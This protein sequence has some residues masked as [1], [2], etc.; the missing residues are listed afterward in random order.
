MSTGPQITV[1][2]M[3]G[4]CTATIC[5]IVVCCL[6]AASATPPTIT[7]EFNAVSYP[8]TLAAFGSNTTA[9]H[10]FNG[11]Q[12]GW[13]GTVNLDIT[14]LLSNTRHS[15]EVTY[16]G[17][18]QPEPRSFSTK[19]VAG[20]DFYLWNRSCDHNS[21]LGETPGSADWPMLR[22]QIPSGLNCAG[23]VWA[24]DLGYV[25]DL[26]VADQA[27]SGHYWTLYPNAYTGPKDSVKSY[28]YALAWLSLFGLFGDTSIATGAWGRDTDRVWG[29]MNFNIFPQWDD[30]EF[31][32]NEG[33]DTVTSASLQYPVNK[34]LWDLL[35]KPLYS[36]QPSIKSA[37]LNANHW[38]TTLG[39]LRLVLLDGITN[40]NGLAPTNPTTAVLYGS[41]GLVN[42]ISDALT[43]LNTSDAFKTLFT[44]G[45]L[46]NLIASDGV[47]NAY[48]AQHPLKNRVPAEYKRLFTQVG[49]APKSIMDNPKLNGTTGIFWIDHGDQHRQNFL[50]H[51]ADAYNDGTNDHAPETIME[52]T[53]GASGNVLSLDWQAELIPGYVFGQTTIVYVDQTS[54]GS[55]IANASRTDVYGSRSPKIVEKRLFTT[56]GTVTVARKFVEGKGSYAYD[57]D[58]VFPR[59]SV[60]FSKGGGI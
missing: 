12:A 49:A 43:A 40:G 5:P 44:S 7:V 28:D 42:Q 55:Y 13:V 51:E 3:A 52:F 56:D 47:N 26:R 23:I 14:G 17:V 41:I 54:S 34:A 46:K 25:D 8:V 20:D 22:S 19:P 24:G 35:W 18:T 59:V 31:T 11:F 15:Y 37:D 58:H 48:G 21:S 36:G 6:S 9:G 45:S 57:I 16:N 29:M 4:A 2:S 27:G 39:D 10:P 53:M 33:W 50:M 38:A 1:G 60:T 32:N 30:H